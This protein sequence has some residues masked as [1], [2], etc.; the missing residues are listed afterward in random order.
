L[1][2]PAFRRRA[3]IRSDSARGDQGCVHPAGFLGHVLLQQLANALGPA[4]A[5][6]QIVD[7]SFHRLRGSS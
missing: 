7:S 4:Q 5:R 3:E 6:E 1:R 2:G